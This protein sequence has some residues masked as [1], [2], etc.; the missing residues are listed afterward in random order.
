MPPK[1]PAAK[2]PQPADVSGGNL[3]AKADSPPAW[4]NSFRG[5]PLIGIYLNILS[6]AQSYYT[7]LEDSVDFMAADLEKGLKS[8]WIGKRVGAKEKAKAS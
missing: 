4:K 7:T 3:V 2:F 8:E 5:W 1:Y 6:Q